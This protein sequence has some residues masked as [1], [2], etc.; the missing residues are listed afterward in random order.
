[1]N[2]AVLQ[3][4]S[5]RPVTPPG[6]GQPTV[7]QDPSAT[8]PDKCRASSHHTAAAA[9]ARRASADHPATRGRES[10][11]RAP[12]HHAGA[13]WS[14]GRSAKPGPGPSAETRPNPR[15]N[16]SPNSGTSY[17][18]RFKLHKARL[19]RSPGRPPEDCRAESPVCRQAS[20]LTRTGN[21]CRTPVLDRAIRDCRQGSRP[22]T[23]WSTTRNPGTAVHAA[24]SRL[25]VPCRAHRAP[26]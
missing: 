26:R 1:M 6:F 24:A 15:T 18:A 8:Q 3:R 4:P 9:G 19:P 16:R 5:D 20:G 2:A 22:A 17:R 21:W 10:A 14:S 11:G 7:V 13:R 23:P 25:R 12:S